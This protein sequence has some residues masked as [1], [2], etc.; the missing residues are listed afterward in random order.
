MFKS[1]H[2]KVGQQVHTKVG[3]GEE[4]GVENSSLLIKLRKESNHSHQLAATK[5]SVIYIPGGFIE[6]KL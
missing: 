4:R 3:E 5:H 6:G 2:V 1:L